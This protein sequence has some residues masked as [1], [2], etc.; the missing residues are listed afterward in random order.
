MRKD[1]KKIVIP[2]LAPAGILYIV[3]FIYPA[4][5]ALIVSMYDWSGFTPTRTFIG[6]AN[7][8]ELLGDKVYWGTLRFTLLILI[9]G[10][11]LIFGIAFLFTGILSS[12]I[13]GKKVLRAVLFF[14]NVVATVALATLW[15]FIYNRNFGLL[16]GFF[17][18]IG[19]EG[20]SKTTWTGPNL[21]PWAVIVALVWIYVGFYVVLLL[22]GVDKI[23]PELFD[24]AKVEGANQLQIFVR[25]TIPLLWDVLT[26]AIVLWGIGAIKQ[27]EFMYAFAGIRPPRP[28]WT[29]AVYMYILSF[30]KRDA[31]FRMGYGTAVAVTLLILVAIF[32]LVSRR[33]MRRD[34][35]E[36]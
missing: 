31:V 35:I 33:L 32:V 27:F 21:I 29:T 36:F 26:I 24:A 10:G 15:A 20:L 6:L 34:P 8:Q 2:F 3:F 28:I 5:Q 30:G 4:I 18:L 11:V 13:R 23:S 14:P 12:G 7:F 9:A 25:I 16:N 1:R 19:L 22:A 17:D